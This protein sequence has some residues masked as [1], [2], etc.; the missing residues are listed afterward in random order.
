[1]GTAS[2]ISD[3]AVEAAA[4]AVERAVE[5][6]ACP[7]DYDSTDNGT[8]LHCVRLMLRAALPHI[9]AAIREKTLRALIAQVDLDRRAAYWVEREDRDIH[10]PDEIEAWLSSLID[11][12]W[13]ARGG[14]R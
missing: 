1:L 14:S 7:N 3:E 9:E 8:C 10:H 2:G 11:I 4:K 13:P 12:G 5:D 6:D